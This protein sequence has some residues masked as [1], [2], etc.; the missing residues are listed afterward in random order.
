MAIG[1]PDLRLGHVIVA[2]VA[3]DPAAEP[4]LRARL[5]GALPVFMQPQRYDWYPALPRNPNGK[6]DR[7]ALRHKVTS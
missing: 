2:A 4:A 6:L 7:A 1:V 5:R 3:G